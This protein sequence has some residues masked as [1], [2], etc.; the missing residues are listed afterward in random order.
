MGLLLNIQNHKNLLTA[1][2]QYINVQKYTELWYE[3][4]TT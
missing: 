1:V 4:A 3:L 2:L